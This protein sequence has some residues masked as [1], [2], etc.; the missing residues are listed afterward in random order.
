MQVWANFAK[1]KRPSLFS[2][3]Y[4]E[5][6]VIP[7]SGFRLLHQSTGIAHHVSQQGDDARPV[8]LLLLLAPS[9]DGRKPYWSVF[10]M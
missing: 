5:H 3:L 7:S 8:S 1:Q 10:K 6:D 4:L 9:A 2:N